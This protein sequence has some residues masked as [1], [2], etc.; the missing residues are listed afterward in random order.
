MDWFHHKDGALSREEGT[1]FDI[2]SEGE[3]RRVHA[4]KADPKRIVLSGV[5]C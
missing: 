3:L 2:V 5:G 4:V 1:G